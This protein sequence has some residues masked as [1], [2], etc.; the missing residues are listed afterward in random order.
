MTPPETGSSAMAASPAQ[1]SSRGQQERSG[2]ESAPMAPLTLDA[3]ML[4]AVAEVAKTQEVP[5][6]Q[7]V[8][9]LSS[10]PPTPP[11]PVSSASSTALDRAADELSRL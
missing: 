4:D 5:A 7:V 1:S 6:S 8:I 3:P 11:T 2:E 9:T 10:S